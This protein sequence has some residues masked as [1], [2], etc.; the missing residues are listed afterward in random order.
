MRHEIVFKRA[1]NDALDFVAAMGPGEALPSEYAMG[2]ALGVSRTTVRKVMAALAAR[3]VVAS[4]E[5]GEGLVTTGGTALGFPEDETV[6]TSA[7]VERQFMEWMLRDDARPG[8]VIN[9][10]DLARRFGVATTSIREF[11][12]R[13]QR[14]GLIEKRPNSGW[15]FQG[16]TESFALELFEIREMFE[17]RSARAFAAVEAGNPQWRTLALL[18]AEHIALLDAIDGRFH[19]FS[20]LDSRFHRLISAAAPNRFI[21]G[22]Y[23]IITLVFHYHYQWNK[24][25]ERQRNAVAI[26]EHLTYIDAL[27]SRD[28]AKIDAA[29]GAHL[30]SARETL[31]RSI[32]PAR[33]RRA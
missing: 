25:D 4:G 11:L 22:F 33:P 5:E 16:F 29:C 2:R 26:R 10:L 6:P 13:F 12:N 18:R 27:E 9:E 31:L 24:K 23:D 7:Q 30:G 14:F 20:D 8:T 21:D 3:G 15:V 32:R 1:F 17:L 28:P 19:D